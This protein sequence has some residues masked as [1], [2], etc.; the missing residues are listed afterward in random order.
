MVE[1]HNYII[2]ENEFNYGNLD[3]LKFTFFN[4]LDCDELIGNGCSVEDCKKQIDY[5]ILDKL[6]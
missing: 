4:S 3:S 6:F 2:Y 5:I 1:Y